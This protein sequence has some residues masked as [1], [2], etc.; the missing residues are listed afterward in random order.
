MTPLGALLGVVLVFHDVS[1]RR[2][3]EQQLEISEVR[4]R[5]LF[6]SAHDGILILDAVTTKVLDVNPFVASL[7]GYPREHFLGKELWE[8]GV[9][10]DSEMSKQAML[11]LQR[12]GRI[13]YEDLPLLH[14]DG[15]HIP[16]EFVSN[17]Y[18]EGRRNV[19]QCNIRD[20]TE[21]KILTEHL[22]K[23]TLAAEAANRSKSEFLA[24][25]SHEIRT[26]MGAIL[27]FAEMLMTKSPEECAQIGCVQIIHRNSLHLLELINEILDLSKVELGS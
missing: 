22:E 14:K 15:R 3:A 4:Y 18:R 13:R 16:V 19:I 24:N 20:I 5:R 17:V 1:N 26:P 10:K 6:E 9:F 7:L 11:T 12:L 21:R 23:A 27:G 8:I 2:Q 25:M